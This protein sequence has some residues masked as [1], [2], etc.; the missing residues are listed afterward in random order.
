MSSISTLPSS[1]HR[2]RRSSKDVVEDV[3]GGARCGGLAGR[4][5]L[6]RTFVTFLSRAY[7]DRPLNG[8]TLAEKRSPL[9][10]LLLRAKR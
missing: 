10:F 1:R 2:H 4:E 3:S 5:G 6:L 8:V 7:Y 9:Y